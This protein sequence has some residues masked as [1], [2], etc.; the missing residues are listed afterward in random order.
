MRFAVLTLVEERMI[1]C[2]PITSFDRCG[3]LKTGSAAKARAH[4]VSRAF[5]KE[6][7]G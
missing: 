7:R 4:K 5:V 3:A 6:A 2:D 1:S